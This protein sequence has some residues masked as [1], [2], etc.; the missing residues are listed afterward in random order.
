MTPPTISC[1]GSVQVAP[2]GPNTDLN[3]N[4]NSEFVDPFHFFQ[5]FL[6]SAIPREIRI[7]ELRGFALFD[8]NL[9]RQTERRKAVDDAEVDG[10]RGAAMLGGL[11]ELANAKNFLRGPRMDIFA[12]AEGLHED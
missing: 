1:G 8:P 12:V 6:H 5:I 7:D 4:R 3:D 11:R 2:V 9:L 10:F